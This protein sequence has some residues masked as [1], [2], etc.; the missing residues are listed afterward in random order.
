MRWRAQAYTSASLGTTQ[1]VEANIVHPATYTTT[2]TVLANS[3]LYTVAA[4]NQTGNSP[5]LNVNGTGAAIDWSTQNAYTML[6]RT[7]SGLPA[8]AISIVWSQSFS[9]PNLGII[10]LEIRG[11]A[12][13][14]AVAHLYFDGVDD[15]LNGPKIIDKLHQVALMAWINSDVGNSTDMLIVGEGD[16]CKLWLQDGNKPRFTIKLNG[17]TAVT[18]NSN[19]ITLG[20]WYHITGRYIKGASAELYVNGILIDSATL[21][22][23]PIDSTASN[24]EVGRRPSVPYQYFKGAMDELRVFGDNNSN[25]TV[26]I[27]PEHIQQMMCQEIVQSGVNVTGAVINKP[28]KTTTGINL[29]WTE[30]MAYYPFSNITTTTTTDASGN[31]KTLTL[32]NATQVMPQTA[33]LPYVTTANGA[34][35]TSGTWVNGGVWNIDNTSV[36]NKHAIVKISH[37]VT[38]SHQ[39]EL[40]GLIVDSN[41]TL[42]VNSDNLIKNNWYLELNGTIDLQNDSQLVQTSMSDLVTSASGKILRR[43]E[44][45][46]NAYHYNY[47]GS[48][49][50]A[51]SAKALTDNNIDANTNNTSFT[52]NMLKDGLGSNI[53]FTSNLTPT[54]GSLSTEWLY[55]F[56]N[57]RTYWDWAQI[58]TGSAINS[59]VGYITKGTNNGAAT[60]QYIF[61]GKPNNGTILVPVTDV[62]G[63]GSVA[64]V[65]KT[66]YLLGNPYPSALNIST[67]IDDN[68]GVISGPLYLWE[69]WGASSHY[70][71]EYDGGYA[72]VTKLGY[73]RASQFIGISGNNTGG[74]E[75]TATPTKYLPVGQGFMVEII[76]NGNVRFNNNQRIFIKESDAISGNFNVGSVFLKDASSVKSK[77]KVLTDEIKTIRLEFTCI[78]GP[79]FRKELLLG[80]SNKTT[81]GFDEGYEAVT[82]ASNSND[83]GSLLDGKMMDIQ[84][85]SDITNDKVVDLV[86][87]SSKYLNRFNLKITQMENIDDSQPIY[88]YDN[89][90]GAYFDLRQPDGCSFNTMSGEYINRLKITFKKVDYTLNTNTP[91]IDSILVYHQDRLYIKNLNM[92]TN[93]TLINMLGQRVLNLNDVSSDEQNNGIDV[94]ELSN[95]A[96]ILQLNTKYGVITKKIIIN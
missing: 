35:T 88:L 63:A 44:G 32:N 83:I 5:R 70:L 64:D 40:V 96:Y 84:A 47:W 37:D 66:D 17:S 22:N 46:G 43:Q 36:D 33:P 75:G 59:G 51:L 91:N 78:D 58:G 10:S 53:S 20:E 81:D 24:F 77:T 25:G 39:S 68:V 8:G 57:G 14:P 62:G 27:Y 11:V 41:K 56:V 61:Q 42:T 65:S 69:Q 79:R 48:P 95:G 6:G 18:L 30:L 2:H 21:T 23:Q 74:L 93:I 28:F 89:D 52:L 87:R 72:T 82:T 13:N 3:T 80:F 34:W 55:T 86:I 45:K 73:T 54:S 90:T 60:Q 71:N 9:N 49:V 50:G 76:A 1:S 12:S 85:F 4:E 31:G 26:V 29:P 19:A 38:M 16:N 94:G 92:T 15:Y 7:V 67:F